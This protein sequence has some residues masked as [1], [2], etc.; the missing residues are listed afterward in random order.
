MQLFAEEKLFE[1]GLS[2]DK[3][4]G[5]YLLSE[6][7]AD[8]GI[9]DYPSIEVRRE[10]DHKVI[11]SLSC[12]SYIQ[13]FNHAY[14]DIKVAWA[15]DCR[16][17]AFLCRGSKTS[18]EVEVY[19]IATNSLLKLPDYPQAIVQHIPSASRGRYF[20]A[21]SVAWH[22][23]DLHV[24]IFGNTHD[25]A[26]NPKDFPDDWYDCTVV[27]RVISPKKVVLRDVII[28]KQPKAT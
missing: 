16:F 21:E 25:S 15:S 5:V 28:H 2:P 6:D 8:V 26:S 22:E 12:D 20:F 23:H 18:R 19:C 10:R 3:T 4:I 27:V 7:R 1:G 13:H 14:E 9:H 11:G 24:R 17:F